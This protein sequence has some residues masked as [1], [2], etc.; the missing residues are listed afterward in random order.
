MTNREENLKKINAELELLSDDELEKISGG[1]ISQT[2]EDSYFL[3][4]FGLCGRYSETGVEGSNNYFND[5]AQADY[6]VHKAWKKAGIECVVSNGE[7]NKYFLG[8]QE[9]SRG[10]AYSIV[11][12]KYQGVGPIITKP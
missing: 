4:R 5:S 7:N 8:K 11:A 3:N 6:E 2:C 9:I 1:S 10:E 12:Q